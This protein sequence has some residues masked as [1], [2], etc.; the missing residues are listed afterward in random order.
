[1]I[2]NFVFLSLLLEINNAK[3]RNKEYN[4]SVHINLVTENWKFLERQG[5][6]AMLMLVIGA[7]DCL[8]SSLGYSSTSSPN[9]VS[10]TLFFCGYVKCFYN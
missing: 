5:N 6:C 1:M 3:R 4:I 2:F 8:V 7:W 9:L 10:S